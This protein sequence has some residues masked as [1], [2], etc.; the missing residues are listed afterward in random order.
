MSKVVHRHE[1]L[2]A[3]DEAF[4]G[5]IRR[6]EN[7]VRLLE[8]EIAYLKKFHSENIDITEVPVFEESKLLEGKNASK[9]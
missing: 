7:Q 4:D 3:A 6:L 2:K 8:S 9:T 5:R 1:V